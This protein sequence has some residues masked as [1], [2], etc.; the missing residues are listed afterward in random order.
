MHYIHGVFSIVQPV[1]DEALDWTTQV[2]D[3]YKLT[4]CISAVLKKKA[5]GVDCR[6]D[7]RTYKK[8]VFETLTHFSI[9]S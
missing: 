7:C 6:L 8:L 4:A 9:F 2:L 5:D 3:Y 1:Q